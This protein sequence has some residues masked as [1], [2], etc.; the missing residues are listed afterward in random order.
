MTTDARVSDER[1]RAIIDMTEADATIDEVSD[2]ATEL[3][4]RRSSSIDVERVKVKA[5]E[6]DDDQWPRDAASLGMLYRI[7]GGRPAGNFKLLYPDKSEAFFDT[8]ADAKAA[9]QADF[10]T[11]ILSA[12]ST[13]PLAV[14]DG[15]AHPDDLAVDRFAAAMKA[16]LAKKR[17]QG[18]SGWEDKEAC[19][20]AFLSSLLHGH[21]IKGDPVD[22]A[23]LA[24]MLHHR[25]ETILQTPNSAEFDPLGSSF[26]FS[27][28]TPPSQAIDAGDGEPVAWARYA[29]DGDLVELI[30][31]PGRAKAFT[32]LGKD[33]RPLYTHPAGIVS[34][35][36]EMRMTLDEILDEDAPNKWVWKTHESQDEWLREKILPLLRQLRA[37]L[38]LG[39]S[40]E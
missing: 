38:S 33:I 26:V 11:R 16:K 27:M 25:G 21:V 7:Y 18:R 20:Q 8:I 28:R 36:D 37:A 23:N 30:S 9:A 2:M 4:E 5:L 12:L 24:M 13:P 19:E 17:A 32:D 14:Q 10:E 40:K 22:V 15:E 39:G 29:D 35:S 3:L 6:W 31:S 1:L 34:V